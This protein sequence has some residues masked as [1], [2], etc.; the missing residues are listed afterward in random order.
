MN[1]PRI[2]IFLRTLASVAKTSGHL[3]QFSSDRRD[4]D[5]LWSP[6]AKA[7]GGLEQ[8]VWAVGASP[9]GSAQAM[10]RGVKAGR[11]FVIGSLPQEQETVAHAESARLRGQRAVGAPLQLTCTVAANPQKAIQIAVTRPLGKYNLISFIDGSPSS[12]PL[13]CMGSAKL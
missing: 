9:S 4:I 6:P 11:R 8:Q 5:G 2:Y 7:G 3:P 12:L 13:A 10:R 1:Y